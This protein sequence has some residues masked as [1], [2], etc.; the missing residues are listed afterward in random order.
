MVTSPCFAE[1]ALHAG[2]TTQGLRNSRSSSGFSSPVEMVSASEYAAALEGAQVSLRVQQRS[3]AIW[4]DTLSAAAGVGGTV[5]E[6]AR[7][8]LLHEVTHLV[9]SP[10]VLQ[11]GFSPDFLRLPR[12]APQPN[13]VAFEGIYTRAAGNA[14]DICGACPSDGS[15]R[16]SDTRVAAWAMCLSATTTGLLEGMCPLLL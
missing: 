13:S 16:D 11:G 10:T 15:V 9:E 14:H 8:D 1:Q 4:R 5:P 3:E 6:S 12:C 2:A 7:G